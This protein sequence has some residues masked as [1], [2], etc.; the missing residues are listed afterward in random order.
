MKQYNV[1][2]KPASSACNLCCRYCFY[3]DE[4]RSRS[5]ADYGRM[6]P[7]TVQAILQRFLEQEADGFA[8]AFQGGEPTLAGLDFYRDF[9]ERERGFRRGKVRHAIQTNGLLLDQQWARFLR[10]NHFLVGLSLDGNK[11][12]HDLYRVDRQGKGS[13]KH[14]FAAARLLEQ[15]QVPFNILTVVTP[16]LARHIPSIF[17]F[18]QE[19]GFRHQQ[20][21]P[22]MGPLEDGAGDY[23]PTPA[24]LESFLKTLFDIWYRELLGGNYVSIRFFDN[25]VYML[26]G[27][28]PELC[29]MCGHCNIQY[30][31]EADGSVFPCDFYALDGY[32]LG[33]IRDCS[34]EEIDRR[35]R[36][37]RFIED[38]LR[39]PEECRS[40]PW[41]YLC[42]NGC[43][44]DRRPGPGGKNIYCAAYRGFFE[45][46]YER[47]RQ[48]A[49]GRGGRI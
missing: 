2:I 33:N 37:L 24:Q 23:V 30:L 5:V 35:R 3:A 9:M 11:A 34:L 10:Q 12:S 32:C 38:S 7:E 45:Y 43:R 17:R 15:N 42:R 46:S 31:I 4:S 28:A 18:F 41:A 6:S 47:L 40:C 26:Q 27:Q 48:V 13:F 1:M 44:R 22:C 29:S 8:F 21:I 39:P 19:N 14:A 36:E 16:Q 20:Y 25:L 49:G